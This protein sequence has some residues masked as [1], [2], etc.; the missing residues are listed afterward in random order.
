MSDDDIRLTRTDRV[1]NHMS[2]PRAAEH[3]DQ[4]PAAQLDPAAPPRMSACHR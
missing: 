2:A 4:L 1:H 3:A